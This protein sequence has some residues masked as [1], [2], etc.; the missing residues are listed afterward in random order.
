MHYLYYVAVEKQEKDKR[1]AE[2]I[3]KRAMQILDSNLFSSGE[4]G[5][6][7]SPKA[8]WYVIG[9]RWSGHLQELLLDGYRKKSLAI[10]NKGKKKED[11]FISDALIKEKS[12]ELEKLWKDMGGKGESVWS[13]RRDAYNP[14]GADDDCMLLDK[15]LFEAMKKQVKQD[16]GFGETEVALISKYESI[17]N[18]MT[19][20]E[21]LKEKCIVGNYWIVVVDYHN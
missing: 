11:T 1:K 2:K 12:V 10:L 19:L 6:W 16:S 9:G 3:K 17:E 8:D 21:F 4:G 15:K 14:N 18:E 13:G 7:G 5:Y 20:K